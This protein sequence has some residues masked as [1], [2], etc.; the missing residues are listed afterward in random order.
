MQI[1]CLYNDKWLISKVTNSNANS[2]KSALIVWWV[3]FVLDVDRCI[4]VDPVYISVFRTGEFLRE[5]PAKE[6]AMFERTPEAVAF[7]GSRKWKKCRRN[8]LSLHPICE[9]CEKLGI[10]AKADHVHHKIYLDTQTYADPLVSM[11]YDN[12]EALCFN[13]HQAEHHRRKDC[14]DGLYFDGDGNLQKG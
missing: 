9:R 6:I 5:F 8:Y 10:I 3:R 1:I 13:C 11:N 7:Y 14:R 2:F 12:L 4:Q